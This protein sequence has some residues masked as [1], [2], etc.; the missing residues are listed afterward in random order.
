MSR[1]RLST[2]GLLVAFI[3]IAALEIAPVASAQDTWT[4]GGANAKVSTTGNWSPAAVPA[5]GDAVI[6]PAGTP[7]LNPNVDVTRT[8]DTMTFGDDNYAVVGDG[9]GITNGIIFN[10][11]TNTININL[12]TGTTSHLAGAQTWTLNG[13]AV[14]WQDD[15]NLNAFALTVIGTGNL[16]FSGILSGTGVN[17]DL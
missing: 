10:N 5:N 12:T 6:F 4:G 8:W 1:F 14:T 15:F 13:A 9:I 2:S 17:S 3:F 7:R 16:T 11:P